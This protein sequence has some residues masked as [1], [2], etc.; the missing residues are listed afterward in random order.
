MK[1]KQNKH[2]REALMY[3]RTG[4]LLGAAPVEVLVRQAADAIDPHVTDG[5]RGIGVA[6]PLM[7]QAMKILAEAY[8]SANAALAVMQVEQEAARVRARRREK[9]HA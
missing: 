8:A 9:T 2:E 4:N 7:A 3:L 5:I 6:L 1:R